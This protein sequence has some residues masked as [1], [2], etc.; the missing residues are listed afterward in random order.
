M[1]N[2]GEG[3]CFC[4]CIYTEVSGL[5]LI[6]FLPSRSAENRL[7]HQLEQLHWTVNRWCLKACHWVSRS[8]ITTSK[9]WRTG[10]Y[11]HTVYTPRC[12]GYSAA[13]SELL[14][15]HSSNSHCVG[16]SANCASKRAPWLFSSMKRQILPETLPTACVR[17]GWVSALSAASNTQ[18]S[19]A[20]PLKGPI[21]SNNKAWNILSLVLAVPAGW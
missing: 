5:H 8:E 15:V 12:L 14:I 2:R 3:Q 7:F 13:N 16:H 4:L 10:T 6:F 19:A 18:D 9:H 20:T 17:W 21:A 11:T 1:H